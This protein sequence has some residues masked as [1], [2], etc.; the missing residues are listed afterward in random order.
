M[1]SNQ[2]LQ[3][4]HRENLIQRRCY[5]D[6]ENRRENKKGETVKG[7]N[8]ITQSSEYADTLTQQSTGLYLYQ[9]FGDTITANPD[10]I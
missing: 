4:F 2:P 10:S 8:G 5:K 3:V 6:R 1:S 9:A 7:K